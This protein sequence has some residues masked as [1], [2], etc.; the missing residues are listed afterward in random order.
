MRVSGTWRR[1]VLIGAVGGVALL[2]NLAPSAAFSNGSDG[3][4]LLQQ[5]EAQACSTSL[6]EQ[7]ASLLHRLDQKSS[8][9]APE[10]QQHLHYLQ[11][12]QAA[13]RGDFQK[14]DA[15]I[16][17]ILRA[18]RDAS[19]R[20]KAAILQVNSLSE[21]SR[22]E[23][24][25]R[26]LSQ[27]VVS[28]QDGQ[29]IASSV[30]EHGFVV[31][32]ALYVDAG[33][34]ELASYYADEIFKRGLASPGYTCVDDHARIAALYGGRKWQGI[35]PLIAQ[36]IEVCVTERNSLYANG[37]RYFAARLDIDRGHPNEAI[38]L[39]RKNYSAVQH[40]G[41]APQLAQ[42]D[43]LLATAYDQTKQPQLARESALAAIAHGT[44]N[45][46]A[47]SIS[48]AYRILYQVAKQQG[49]VASALAYHEKYMTADKGYL[50]EVS[51]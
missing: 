36:G 50:D 15:L 1:N 26:Q 32:S 11:A 9:L 8:H 18:S 42:F 10:Q 22:F 2:A 5:A 40:D 4:E 13:L 33:Q 16:S 45:R 14:S 28:L 48:T 37:I 49:D 6:S 21:Q 47:E 35:D 24:A 30:R 46:Y 31:A 25:F 39:L 44:H 7:C 19:L 17:S 3:V 27:V 23:E 51:A 20:L 38:A 12:W 29:D 41:Y 43:A 34:Y